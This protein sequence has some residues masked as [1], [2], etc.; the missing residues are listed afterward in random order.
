MPNVGFHF[1][2]IPV[3]SLRAYS[4]FSCMGLALALGYWSCF[5]QESFSLTFSNQVWC[6][7]AALNMCYC[8]WFLV[9]AAVKEHIFGPIR[10]QEIENIQDTFWNFVFHKCIFVF[11]VLNVQ[12]VGHLICWV[13][14]L[15]VL[16]SLYILT[17]LCIDRSNAMGLRRSQSGET[18]VKILVLLLCILAC[19][20]LLVYAA[21]SIGY[22]LGLTYSVLLAAELIIVIAKVLQT[23]IEQQIHVWNINHPEQLW[24]NKFIYLHYTELIFSL[25]ALSIDF[26]HHIHMLL[27]VDMFLSM[28]SLVLLMKLRF[29]Y[30]EIYQ[31]LEK[32]RVHWTITHN[33]Q[34]LLG[35]VEPRKEKC[36]ICWDNINP[37]R[38]LRCGHVF[39]TPCL[40]TWL[41]DHQTCPVCREDLTYLL[42]TS[43]QLRNALA[44]LANLTGHGRGAQG[45]RRSL[46]T[47]AGSSL[48]SW[49]PNFSVEVMDNEVVHT[50]QALS[51]R[52]FDL[53]VDQ[54][55]QVFPHISPYLILLDLTQT[56]S[57]AVTVENIVQGNVYSPDQGSRRSSSDSSSTEKE[58]RGE[59]KR[60][61]EGGED[62]VR[63]SAPTV[64]WADQ[65]VERE[66]LLASKREL[67]IGTNRKRYLEK[68]P[69]E[70]N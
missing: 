24:E 36:T 16:G 61:V 27:W 63:K 34:N 39:H 22:F 60:G 7:A 58:D 20:G 48:A 52:E 41:Q 15:G 25:F 23:I 29:L 6:T 70:A 14:W 65:P 33:I 13:G 43:F 32:H 18:H 35:W 67:L 40:Y 53:M 45:Q 31:K 1:E 44:V 59:E 62:P 9:L 57:M 28:A 50:S 42:G 68:Y 56:S 26:F 69:D 55:H 30:Q 19:C 37:G 11:G 54:I 49:L 47:F 66:N 8:S 17:Q 5:S 46:F 12:D 10:R 2:K 21:M 38:V 64:K 4:Y 51:A 3:P